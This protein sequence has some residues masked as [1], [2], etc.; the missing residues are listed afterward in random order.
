MPYQ[1]QSA[2]T[3]GPHGRRIKTLDAT[4]LGSVDWQKEARLALE[5]EASDWETR[6]TRAVARRMEMFEWLAAQPSMRT[7][8]KKN[9]TYGVTWAPTSW[10]G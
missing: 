10:R 2:L 7:Y 3:I 6:T 4:L 8:M 9:F 1:K 5:R